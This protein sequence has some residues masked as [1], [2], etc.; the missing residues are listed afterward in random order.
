MSGRTLESAGVIQGKHAPRCP[1]LSTLLLCKNERLRFIVDS[2]FDQLHGLKVLDLSRTAI[3]C[4]PDSVSDLEGLTA[5]LLTHCNKLR[6]VPSLEKLRALK[7]LDLSLAPLINI[8][9]GMECLSNLRYLRMNGCGENKFPGGI[10]PKLCD[11]QVFILEEWFFDYYNP[12]TVEGKEVGCLRKL[13][14]L[15]C[16]FEDQSNYL[17]YLKFRD[18][19]QTLRTYK[20]KVGQLREDH[21][22]R[23]RYRGSGSKMVVLGNLNINRDADFLVISS[24]DIQQLICACI[25]ARTIGDVLPLKYSLSS[26]NSMESLVSSSWFC[27]GQLPQP[28]PSY[29]GI[30]SALKLLSCYGCKSMEK[31][32]PSVL[33]PNLVNLETISVS[34]CEKM[35]EIIGGTRS[36]EEG[37]MGEESNEFKLPKLRK[38]IFQNLPELKSICSAKLICDSLKNIYVCECNSIEILVPSSWSCLLKLEQIFVEKCEKMEEIIGGTRSDERVMG[39]ESISSE[40]KLPK[41]RILYLNNLPELKSICRAKETCDSLEEI[42]VLHCEKLKRMGIC[43]PLLENGQPSHPPSLKVIWINPKEWWESTVEWEH[44]N[45]KDVLRPFVSFETRTIELHMMFRR[46]ARVT[47]L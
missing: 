27:S 16:H 8:P 32:F 10:L 36:D 47:D 14:S 17:E 41:L 30:F 43:L 6:L 5:L 38:L 34:E 25:D 33:V 11:L 20:I 15:E 7:K 9:H 44:P 1:N 45:A 18:A 46:Q 40:F 22:P 42:A 31:L 24:N 2:F 13:E 3:Q 37:A 12:I 23:W 4:L 29:N 35:E 28:S 19:T 39:K 21:D 26:C